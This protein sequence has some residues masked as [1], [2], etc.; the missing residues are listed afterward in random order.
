VHRLPW[1]GNPSPRAIV[2]ESVMT[3]TMAAKNVAA[4]RRAVQQQ[5]YAQN[6]DNGAS[7]NAPKRECGVDA[8]SANEPGPSSA[9]G[10]ASVGDMA[11]FE[12]KPS[13]VRNRAVGVAGI[14]NGVEGAVEMGS[15]V[16]G[17]VNRDDHEEG[18]KSVEVLTPP[19]GQQRC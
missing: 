14:S 6:G 11:V 16:S 2:P 7:E 4:K 1:P 17:H 5:T 3:R 9:Y 12:Q 15:E 13:P 19:R 18:W 8:S 10:A